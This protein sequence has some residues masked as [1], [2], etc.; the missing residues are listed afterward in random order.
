MRTEVDVIGLSLLPILLTL[1]QNSRSISLLFFALL[2]FKL[3]FKCRYVVLFILFIYFLFFHSC[4]GTAAVVLLV[5]VDITVVD[6]DKLVVKVA[7]VV[8]LLVLVVAAVVFVIA[9][10]YNLSIDSYFI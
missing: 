4:V 1:C 8:V 10:L 3:F 6:G 5:A 2:Y 9:I 7:A